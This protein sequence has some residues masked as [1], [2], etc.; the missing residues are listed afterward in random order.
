M[1]PRELMTRWM[2][3]WNRKDADRL[4]ELVT[5]DIVYVDPA[6]PEPLRGREGVR[7]FATAM[8]RAMPNMS[9]HE[10]EGGFVSLE[11]ARCAAPWHM[12]GT[13]T[14]PLEPPGYAPTGD[15]VELDGVDVWELRDGLACRYRAYYD[16]TEIARQIG[17]LPRPGTRGERAAVRLQ[18]LMAK[19]KRL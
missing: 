13:F 9:F 4:L 19:R 14:G 3:A 16:A 11:G 8:W 1:E 2:D 17:V 12:E 5:D 18:R 10:P 6:W 7:T 15:R